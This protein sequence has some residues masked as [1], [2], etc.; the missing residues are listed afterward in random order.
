[1]SL[2]TSPNYRVSLALQDHF[3]R[4]ISFKKYTEYL[5]SGFPSE[6]VCQICYD[7]LFDPVKLDCGNKHHLHEECARSLFKVKSEAKCPN[8]KNVVKLYIQDTDFQSVVSQ[9]VYPKPFPIAASPSITDSN[10]VVSPRISN[11]L[12]SD[13][14]HRNRQ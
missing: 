9:I 10:E 11:I 2:Y 8:C 13:Y 1:M 14:F 5:D 4:V 3:Q 6:V 7:V 12:L